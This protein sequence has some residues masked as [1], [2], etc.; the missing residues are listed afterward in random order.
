MCVDPQTSGTPS[1]SLRP[2]QRKGRDPGCMLTCVTIH[3]KGGGEVSWPS[4]SSPPNGELPRKGTLW[5]HA[6]REET[7]DKTSACSSVRPFEAGARRVAVA[8]FH[9][10]IVSILSRPRR[11]RAA[12]GRRRCARRVQVEDGSDRPRRAAGPVGGWS[13]GKRQ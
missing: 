3:T 1:S 6:A 5:L 8:G 10:S 13:H 12:G 2:T 11:C 7:G 9:A 4:T